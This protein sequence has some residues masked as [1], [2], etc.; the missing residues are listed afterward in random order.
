ML[1]P[2]ASAGRSK[3]LRYQ[4]MPCHCGA[5]L[6]ATSASIRAVCGK[7]T[8]SQVRSSNDGELALGSSA[9]R[10]RQAVLKV[11]FDLAVSA[12]LEPKRSKH[13]EQAIRIGINDRVDSGC[14]KGG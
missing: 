3:A 2:R 5:L 4:Q 14:T 7:V 10:N 9:R 1:L 12:L 13:R 6:P 8:V 11:S